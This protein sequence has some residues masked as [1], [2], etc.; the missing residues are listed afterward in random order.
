MTGV[1]TRVERIVAPLAPPSMAQDYL[2]S[3]LYFLRRIEQQN[4]GKKC[5]RHYLK[6]LIVVDVKQQDPAGASSGRDPWA[7]PPVRRPG[8]PVA[9][10]P[11]SRT[12]LKPLSLEAFAFVSNE[13]NRATLS[14]LKSAIQKKGIYPPPRTSLSTAFP[15][16]NL[17]AGPPVWT[18]HSGRTT[19]STPLFLR[20][21]THGLAERQR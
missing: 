16:S 12:H 15:Q 19:L 13:V 3:A 4:G 2:R 21:A 18:R 14:P 17:L 10:I 20:G 7:R 11:P 8:M 1:D 5:F 6:W 9:T